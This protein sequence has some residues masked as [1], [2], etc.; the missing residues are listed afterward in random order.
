[1]NYESG[2]SDHG[3]L[4]AQTFM[5]SVSNA[6]GPLNAA[7]RALDDIKAEGL[8]AEELG[9]IARER[10]NLA[11][12]RSLLRKTYADAAAHRELSEALLMRLIP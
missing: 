5:Q 2:L 8:T 10:N 9:A 4:L 7:M 11:H 12:F 6:M 3:H 1:M